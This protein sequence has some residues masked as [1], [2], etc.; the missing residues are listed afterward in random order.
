MNTDSKSLSQLSELLEAATHKVLN[1]Q[2][3]GEHE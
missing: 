3:V 2:E 1:Q